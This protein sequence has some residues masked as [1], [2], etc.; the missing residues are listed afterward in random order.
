MRPRLAFALLLVVG[1]AGCATA[2]VATP[3]GPPPP[4]VD[5][6][7]AVAALRVESEP[8]AE[9]RI[10]KAGDLVLPGERLVC[11]KCGA[12]LVSPRDGPRPACADCG[13][14]TFRSAFTTPYRPVIDAARIDARVLA[15]VGQRGALKGVVAVPGG[16]PDRDRAALLE[17][18]R[19]RGADLLFEP[20]LED[21][22]VELVR[23]TGAQGLKV[24]ILI[25]SSLLLVPAVDPPNWFIASEVYGVVATGR[26]RLL[27]VATGQLVR[28]APFRAQTE[29][30]FAELGPGPTRDW[31]L[32][33]FLRV[34]SCIDEEEWAEIA[35]QLVPVA[36]EDLASAIVVAAESAASPSVH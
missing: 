21:A 10:F 13:G 31:H 7:L 32:V 4:R 1:V 28:E 34:P 12:E 9:R 14:V 19:A 29:G 3:L 27:D 24:A 33:G 26:W 11:V 23:T 20:T 30:T 2:P 5:H 22:R 35:A 15:L 36:H 17:A 8:T 18:A 25:V 16:D 6:V